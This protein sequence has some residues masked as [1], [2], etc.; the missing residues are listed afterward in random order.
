MKIKFAKSNIKSCEIL[1]EK[2]IKVVIAK[3]EKTI[4]DKNE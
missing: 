2:I 3:D 4:N 1:A